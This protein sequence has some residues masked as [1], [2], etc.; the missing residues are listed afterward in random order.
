MTFA[1][2]DPLMAE[3]PNAELIQR[4]YKAFSDDGN[5]NVLLDEFADGFKWHFPGRSM[6]AGD[7]EGRDGFLTY[8]GKLA[9]AG[10]ETTIDLVTAFGNDNFVT[11]I[12]HV[13][14]ERNGKSYDQ[15]DIVI[16]R[17]KGGKIAEA[18]GYLEDP[19]GW[20]DVLS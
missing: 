11:A 5:P 10:G 4:A 17:F 16:F 7:Y 20:D 19:Y 15:H 9:E 6:L 8:L 3:H 12:E 13:K 2:Y 1:T 14:V 18:W